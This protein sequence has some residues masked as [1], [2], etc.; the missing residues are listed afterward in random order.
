MVVRSP[1]IPATQHSPT[2]SATPSGDAPSDQLPLRVTLAFAPLHKRAFGVATGTA[3][4][5]GLFVLTMVEV[6][7]HPLGS[8]LHLLDEYFAGYSVSVVGAI[9]GGLWGFATAFVLGWFVAFCRNFVVAASIFWIRTRAQL[10]A[11]RDFLDH[12]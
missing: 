6:L 10:S 5:L 3:A 1:V 2:G 9:I 8:P 7:R 11:T 12:I 4:G